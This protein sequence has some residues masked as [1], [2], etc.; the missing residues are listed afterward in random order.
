M[1]AIL[2]VIKPGLQTT[3]QDLG[4]HG[5]QQYGISPSGA[6][7]SFSMQIAN[8]LVGN[9]VGEAVLE[10]SFI[11]P[12]L[13]A[14][15]DIV[16]AVCGGFSPKVDGRKVPMWKSFLLKKGQKLQ[17]GPSV[18]GARAYLAIAGGIDVPVVLDSKSTFLSSGFGGYKG[19][20]LQKGDRLSGSP[21]IRKPFKSLHPGLIPQF[22]KE[23]NIRVIIGPHEEMF[24]E[25][26]IIRFFSETY[27]VTPKSN[28]MGYQ[29]KGPKL[30]H[31]NGPDIISDPVPLGGIQVPA[32]GQPIILMADRQTT[33]GYTRIGTVISADLPLLAQAVPGTKIMFSK[34]SIE[35]A[36]RFYLER[37]RLIKLLAMT[38][39]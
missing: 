34:V 2:K 25:K 3:V 30:E 14:L 9:A 31:I 20:A 18:N 39:K 23:L 1:T 7:D 6:M 13:E 32:S 19:R 4:R 27:T 5:Y 12:E 17:I 22:E 11:G 8:I 35:E 37:G 16:I 28:R 36:Q 38:V 21:V 10:A 29:L 26:S 24:S 15:T 33:G